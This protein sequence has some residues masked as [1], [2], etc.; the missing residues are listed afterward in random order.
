MR[1]AF[2]S[3]SRK[4]GGHKDSS[5]SSSPNESKQ[6]SASKVAAEAQKEADVIVDISDGLTFRCYIF[7][8]LRYQSH[9][10]YHRRTPHQTQYAVELMANSA[11][12]KDTPSSKRQVYILQTFPGVI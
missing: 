6:G 7:N 5:S 8:N 12:L 9:V 1:K 11:R 2:K 3:V 4:F 10:V